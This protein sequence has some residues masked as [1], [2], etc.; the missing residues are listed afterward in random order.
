LA[1]LVDDIHAA[2][3]P[4]RG[5]ARIVHQ[6]VDRSSGVGESCDD[7]RTAFV[8]DEISWPDLDIDTVLLDQ[9]GAARREA[10]GVP[11][12]KDQVTTLGR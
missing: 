7:P 8:R 1:F 4:V 12:D 5:D 11:R 6:H 3:P 9:R 10:V 2:K